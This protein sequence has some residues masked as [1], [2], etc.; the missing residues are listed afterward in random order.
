MDNI[1]PRNKLADATVPSKLTTAPRKIVDINN[2]PIHSVGEKVDAPEGTIGHLQDRMVAALR[3]MADGIE[4]GEMKMPER[5]II[6]PKHGSEIHLIH[7]GDEVPVEYLEGMLH[8]L[9]TRMALQ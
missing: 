5:L 9:V 8:K 2:K 1:P 3:Q 7:L 4:S 6:L